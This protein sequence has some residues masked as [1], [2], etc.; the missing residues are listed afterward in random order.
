[1]R[2]CA[3]KLKE[4]GAEP[5]P[6]SCSVLPFSVSPSPPVKLPRCNSQLVIW[7][8]SNL[9]SRKLLLTVI[10]EL[11]KY[12]ACLCVILLTTASLQRTRGGIVRFSS[13]QL[14]LQRNTKQDKNNTN[15]IN[16]TR[17]HSLTYQKEYHARTMALYVQSIWSM[18]LR[19][20][21]SRALHHD[22]ADYHLAE[23]SHAWAANHIWLPATANAVTTMENKPAKL[24]GTA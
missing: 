16:T 5:T 23:I 10:T 2:L 14:Q 18:W 22:L 13:F 9:T 15:M 17:E 21:N 12:P 24:C 6:S 3:R 1:M 7:T 20:W 11:R 8:T 4:E 19:E